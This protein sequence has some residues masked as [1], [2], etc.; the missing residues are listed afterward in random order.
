M[1]TQRV[2]GFL[3]KHADR[4]F[5]LALMR[6]YLLPAEVLSFLQGLWQELSEARGSRG[7]V[8]SGEVWMT[9]G[10]SLRW[11]GPQATFSLVRQAAQEKN[12]DWDMFGPNLEDPLWENQV[13]LE[14]AGPV[15]SVLA[16][17]AASVC[18]EL[19]LHGPGFQDVLLALPALDRFWVR[20]MITYTVPGAE[21]YEFW[22]AVHRVKVQV[23]AQRME[24]LRWWVEAEAAVD[25]E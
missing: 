11:F 14:L 20:T 7:R 10:L 9:V 3:S 12:R 25:S 23:R 18:L 19:D 21:D 4:A 8:F 6:H 22:Q 24:V 15:P 5:D 13:V 1:E 17:L 16:D 2:L